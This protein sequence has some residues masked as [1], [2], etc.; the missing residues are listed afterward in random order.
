MMECKKCNNK[1]TKEYRAKNKEKVRA[2]YKLWL[3][4]NKDK[5]KEYQKTPARKNTEFKSRYG[6]TLDQRNK[7][8]EEQGGICTIC[9]ITPKKLCVDHCHKTNKV[10]N[11]LCDN[12]NKV[13][14]LIKEN[15]TTAIK[16][17]DYLKSWGSNGN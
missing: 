3:E 17:H 15:S 6:I 14:G 16:M 10:R 12:C 2:T 7:M 4:K 11:L 1:R 13:L 8:A 5:K 9:G